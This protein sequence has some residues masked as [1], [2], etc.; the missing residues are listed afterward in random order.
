MLV[1]DAIT[2]RRILAQ[3]SDYLDSVK[4]LAGQAEVIWDDSGS[5]TPVDLFSETQR[6]QFSELHEYVQSVATNLD[7]KVVTL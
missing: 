5:G 7:S 2:L 4:V 6:T 3:M 1:S